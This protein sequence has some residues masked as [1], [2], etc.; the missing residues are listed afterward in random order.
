MEQHTSNN[1]QLDSKS[2]SDHFAIYYPHPLTIEIEKKC[3]QKISGDTFSIASSRSLVDIIDR[4]ADWLADRHH[5]TS[6][7][8]SNQSI[9]RTFI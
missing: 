1:Y 3:K 2:S 8:P 6:S 5:K 4:L 9:V 7:R